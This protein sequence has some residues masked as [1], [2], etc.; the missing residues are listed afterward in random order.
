MNRTPTLCTCIPTVPASAPPPTP[1]RR[2][3]EILGWVGFTVATQTVAAALF[4]LVGAAQMAQWAAG[5][6][7]RLVKVLG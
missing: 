1:S 4:T 3:A 6:H 7:T 2:A 5:K